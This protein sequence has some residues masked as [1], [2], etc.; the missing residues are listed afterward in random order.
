MDP[1]D[2]L[3]VHPD[4]RLASAVASLKRAEVRALTARVKAVNGVNMGQ[5]SNLL[6]TPKPLIDAAYAA[7]TRGYNDYTVQEG[8]PELRAAIADS[9]QAD[10]S[11]HV[12]PSTQLRITSGASGG[13]YSICRTILQ[14]GAQAIVLEPYYPYHVTALAMTGCEVQYVRLEPP[15]WRISVE[16][17]RRACGPQTRALVLCNPSNPS[18]RVYSLSELEALVGFCCANGIVVIADEVYG[19]LTY[20]G[21]EHISAANIAGAAEHVVTVSSFSK[22]HAITGWRLGYMYGPEDLIERATLV[23]DCLYVC[24]PRPFQHA[25]ADVLKEHSVDGAEMRNAFSWRRDSVMNSLR[26]A[27]FSTLRVEGAYYMMADYRERYGDISSNEACRRL[28]EENRIATV[29]GST[30]YHEGYDPQLLRFCYALPE[31]DIQ[32]AIELLK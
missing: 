17:L 22:S 20:D 24:A 23:H 18:C 30:F 14:P 1:E 16:A 11:L 28:F 26:H 9:I 19:S 8:I 31:S 4:R 6:P 21:L 3:R 13:F 5:G 29:P 2:S 7:M 32:R 15:D 12:D 10:T 27:G 25:M